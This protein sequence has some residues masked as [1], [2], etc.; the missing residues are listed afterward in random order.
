M[1]DPPKDPTRGSQDATTDFSQFAAQLSETKGDP[2]STFT[3]KSA[4]EVFP[5]L[6]RQTTPRRAGMPVRIASYE[7][8]S[9]LGRGGM[10]VVY[11][12][13]D[14]KLK[15]DVAIKVV[16][17][18][19]HAGKVEFARFQTEAESVARLNHPNV[20]KVYEVGEDRDLPFLALEYCPG[21]S[22]DDRLESSPPNFRESAELVALLTDAVEHAHQSGIIHR[23]LKPA[24]VLFDANGTPKLTD[25]G[26]AKK[27]GDDDSYTRT[28]S[29]LGSA[30]YMS[31]EQ[32]GGNTREVTPAA[33]VY[34]LGA[35]LYRLLSGHI[36]FEGANDLETIRM[37]VGGAPVT[38][39]RFRPSCPRDLETICFKCLEKDPAA[40]Y[41][42]AAALGE[43]LRR[44]LRGEPILARPA[45]PLEQL[46][47]W[48]RRN[49]LPTS[50]AVLSIVM[51]ATLAG[52]LAWM[53]YRNYRV[54]ETI[55]AREMRVQELRGQ[56]LHLDE[57]LTASALLASHSGDLAW[58]TR[59]REH[60]P[61]L[62]AALAEAIELVPAAKSDLTAV[63]SANNVLV[64]LESRALELVH[65][66]D[67][68]KARELLTSPNYETHKQAYNQGLAHF[69]ERLQEHSAAVVAAAHHEATL[70][71]TTAAILAAIVLAI[72]LL[73]VYALLRSL[74]LHAAN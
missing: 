10:G 71:L 69:A 56:I 9:E 6:T 54:L 74:R 12:G 18:G 58:E 43:D 73:A 45:S 42:S 25:F 70:F 22:L 34:A 21:G 41:A 50:I 66:G 2:D 51:L 33:D 46:V 72:I 59:Y 17:A 15:R 57:V 8:L 1:S 65:N 63:E 24:N 53:S 44:Y 39:R 68:T 35:M 55:Q 19:G 4:D 27:V 5:Q 40:R 31:P 3:N 61:Q 67:E 49:P 26:L 32:A 30:A 16:L 60:E 13:H 23:D 11:H 14:L 28:G 29:I 37:I 62:T 36:V 64:E 48:C 52:I 47:S 38:I 20:V 7:I